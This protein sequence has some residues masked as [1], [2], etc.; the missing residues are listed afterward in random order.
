MAL[1]T[2]QDAQLA[3]GHVAL[4]DHTD[5]ALEG[6]EGRLFGPLAFTKTY[7]MAGA[8]ILSVTLVPVLMGWLIRGKI[9]SEEKNPINFSAS[10]NQFAAKAINRFNRNCNNRCFLLDLVAGFSDRTLWFAFNFGQQ[11]DWW[12]WCFAAGR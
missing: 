4:L 7:A 3:F 10:E 2:L 12:R 9:P 5:F 1:I 6:Q 8:A 11:R